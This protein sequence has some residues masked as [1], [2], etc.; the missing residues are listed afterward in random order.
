MIV[1]DASAM[2]EALVGQEP[3]EDLLSAL[4]GEVDAPSLV[5]VEVLAALRGLSLGGKLDRGQAEQAL[6]DHC[7]LTITRH[8]VSPFADRIWHLRHQLTAYDACYVALAE[9][10]RAPLYTCDARLARA[11]HDA[12]VRV[13]SAGR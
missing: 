8:P 5:D 10:L 3:H 12:E 6:R 4:A 11:G 7:S 13:V 1:V 9:A 2:V